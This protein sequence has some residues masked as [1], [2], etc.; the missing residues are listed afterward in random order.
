MFGEGA[1]VFVVE[2]EEHARA[3]GAGVHAEILGGALTSD[4]HHLT[5]PKPG[6]G[7]AAAAMRKALES[8]SRGADDID[9]VYAHATSTPLGDIAEA[10][11]IKTVFGERRVPVSA[12]K[13]QLGHTF[14]AA[15][16]MSAL[17]AIKSIEEGVISPTIN[18][19][20]PDPDC[21]LDCVPNEARVCDVGVAMV[22]AFGFGG[23]NVV[24]VLGG[25]DE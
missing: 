7:G 13:S 12:T 10:L 4:A 8:S 16:A 1:A 23:Q 22:N 25:Y 6:G 9:V 14:G 3:R 11:A 21:D 5:M 2:T 18:Y 15:G 19:T 17:A 20:T 24:L